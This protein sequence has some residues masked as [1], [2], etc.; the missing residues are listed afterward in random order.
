MKVRPSIVTFFSLVFSVS[1]AG[2]IVT[3]STPDSAS[4]LVVSFLIVS[5]AIA[6]WSLMATTLLVLRQSISQ[7]VW[8]SL[9][10]ALTTVLLILMRQSLLASPR[11]L[12]GVLLATL[13]GSLSAWWHLRRFTQHHD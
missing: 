13:V 4:A 9:I 12:G 6:V 1:A 2:V 8:V 11:L 10:P 5:C 7:A 3:L